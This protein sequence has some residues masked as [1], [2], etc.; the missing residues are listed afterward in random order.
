[1]LVVG[2]PP[3]DRAFLLISISN[4]TRA[5]PKKGPPIWSKKVQESAQAGPLI[6]LPK[7]NDPLEPRVMSIRRLSYFLAMSCAVLLW[8]AETAL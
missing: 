4:P 2:P 8:P 6:S 1:M 3:Y 7:R 5:S